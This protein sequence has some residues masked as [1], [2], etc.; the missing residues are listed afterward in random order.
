MMLEQ[1]RRVNFMFLRA[2]LKLGA[3]ERAR[4]PKTRDGDQ[5]IKKE[6]EVLVK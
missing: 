4:P 5:T 6:E 1:R 2:N 3:G